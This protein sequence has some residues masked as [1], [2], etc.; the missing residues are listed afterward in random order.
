VAFKIINDTADGLSEAAEKAVKREITAAL[1]MKSHPNVVSVF[2]CV[3]LP[4][5]AAVVMEVLPEGTLLQLLLDK[6]QPFPWPRRCSL[7]RGVASGMEALHAN[8]PFPIVHRD[9]KASNI[10]LAK[11]KT[12]AKIG[13]FGLAKLTTA[14]AGNTYGVGTLSHSSAETFDGI[15]NERSDSYAFGMLSYEVVTRVKAWDTEN[16]SVQE[17]DKAVKAKFQFSQRRFD[18]KGESREEQLEDWIDDN[19]LEDRRPYLALVEPGCPTALI[20][21]ISQCWADEPLSRPTFAEITP[22]IVGV[23]DSPDAPPPDAPDPDLPHT[24]FNSHYQ[25][26]YAQA[27]CPEF[28]YEVLQAMTLIIQE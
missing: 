1:Q 19:P 3:L 21:M 13:D 5:G 9:L 7:L 12:V 28:Q 15:F 25:L 24:F 26:A 8:L 20:E 17:I 22:I 10:M 18:K 11:N 14:A 27:A 6:L 23:F 4:E 2:G 16:K